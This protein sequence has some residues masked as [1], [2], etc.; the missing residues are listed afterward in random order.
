METRLSSL[1]GD[2]QYGPDNGLQ[3]KVVVEGAGHRERE[4]ARQREG[5]QDRATGEEKGRM[6]H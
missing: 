4:G 3:S 2:R 6:A 1:S 5:G